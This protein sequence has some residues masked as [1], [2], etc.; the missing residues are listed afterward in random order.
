MSERSKAVEPQAVRDVSGV[1]S[2]ETEALK[3]EDLAPKYGRTEV[4]LCLRGWEQVPLGDIADIRSG[5]TPSTAVRQYWNGGIPWCTPTDITALSGRKYLFET[6][7]TIAS[8]GVQASSAELIPPKS[9]I[10]TTRATIG[11]CAINTVGMTTNQGFKNLV[12]QKVEAEFLYYLMGAQK[13]RLVQLCGGSTFLEIAKKPLE[14]FKVM[15]PV[16]AEEQRAIATA[17]SDA[18]ALIESLDRLIAKKR[19][20]KQAAMQQLLTGQTRLPGFTGEWETKRLGELASFHKGIGLAKAELVDD[21]ANPCIHYGELFTEYRELIRNTKSRTNLAS[22]CFKSLSND[23]LM[24]TS[25]VTP[26]GLATASCIMKND[27]ILGGDILVIRSRDGEIDGA[28]LAYKIGLDRNQIM[29]LVSGTTV[30]HIYGRDMANFVYHAPRIEEQRAI[31]D[32]LTLMGTE[33]EALEHRCDKARQIKQG[34]MQELLTGRTRLV[35][36][37]RAA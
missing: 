28:F 3:T 20:I 5:G 29:Q 32:S 6:E 8:G 13:D 4:G 1:Y 16:L 36:P 30:F 9:V 14:Q 11:E 33:I 24:P 12:P 15:L 34:M 22:L 25:D 35:D 19:A 7:R 21:G 26:N 17:L 2:V 18:D 27:V 31:V 10:M 23:V 37:E